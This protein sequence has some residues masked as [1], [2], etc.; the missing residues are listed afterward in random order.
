MLGETERKHTCRDSE[1]I[2][3]LVKQRA[4]ERGFV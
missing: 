1:E 3:R 4:A 2:I